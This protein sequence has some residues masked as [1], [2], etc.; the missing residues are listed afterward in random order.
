MEMTCRHAIEEIF[1]NEKGV[2]SEKEI[3]DIINKKH[4]KRWKKG[5]IQNFLVALSVNHPLRKH[6]KSYWKYKDLFFIEGKG[7]RKYYPLED[8]LWETTRDG[9]T[10]SNSIGEGIIGEDK[11]QAIE[12]SLSLERDLEKTLIQNLEQLEPNLMLFQEQ[13]ISGQ[14]LDTGKVGRIDILGVDRNR[15]LVVI[16]LKT[17]KADDRVCGQIL[18]YMGWVKEN[19]AKNMNVRGIIVAN[20]F[21]ESLRYAVRAMSDV[22]LKKYE[23]YF[24]FTGI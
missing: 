3:V 2:L 9:T 7:Y 8:G 4:P 10:R 24:R 1:N 6:H 19:L 22:T 18:R 13:G 15:N 17:G 14:Q 11:L 21:T 23:F 20:D 12:T 5:T 16:E